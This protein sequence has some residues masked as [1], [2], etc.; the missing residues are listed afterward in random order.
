MFK[1]SSLSL[2]NILLFSFSGR[3]MLHYFDIFIENN[4]NTV[5]QNE[6]FILLPKRFFTTFIKNYHADNLVAFKRELK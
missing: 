6:T 2:G 4:I 1:T 5:R 3:L